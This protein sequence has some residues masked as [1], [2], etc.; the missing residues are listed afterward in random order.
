MTSKLNILLITADQFRA[1]SM[2]ASGHPLVKTPNLDRLAEEG[3][4]FA[5]HYSQCPP[6]GPSRTSL[7][8]GMYLMNHRSVRNGTPLDGAFTNIAELARQAAYVPWLIGYTDITLDPRRFHPSDPRIGT[9][10][11]LLPGIQQFSPGGEEA[12]GDPAWLAQ[13]R[14]LGYDCWNEPFRQKPEFAAAALAKGPTYAPSIVKSEHGLTA[15]AAD[16]A[17]RFFRQYAGAPWFLHVSFQRPHPPFVAPEPYH[18]MY[19]LEDVPDFHALRSLEDERAIHPFMAYRLERLEMNPKLPLDI[20]HPNDSTA[21][22]QA[23]ATYYGLITELDHYIGRMVAALKQ[24]GIYDNTLIVFTSDHAEMLGDHWCWGKETP[25]DGAVRVPMIVKSPLVAAGARGRVVDAFTEHV[26]VVPTILDHIGVETP[27]QCD[28]RSLRPFLEGESSL[29]WRDAA[30]WDLDFRSITDESVD[31]QFGI[32]I[33]ECCLAAVRTNNWKYVHF[34]GLPPLC[35]D[36]E[37]DPHELHNLAGLAGHAELERDMA[38][39]MLNWRIVFNRREL[40]GVRVHDGKQI[41]AARGRR[42]V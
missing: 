42:I 2:S 32:S 1:D 20:S 28:G 31:R 24:L 35:Y 37:A 4:R 19:R 22:R 14:E 13:L 6:C 9:Y 16:Q 23:R 34:A 15:F 41:Q 26:D 8:T 30:H 3:M 29:R 11:Q 40:T 39:R 27:L 33:D 21:W 10:E 5:Q 17:L 25:F 36:L 7:L 38:R 18:D 12:S